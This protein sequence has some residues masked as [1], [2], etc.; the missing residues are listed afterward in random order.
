MA[1]EDESSRRREY[2][3]DSILATSDSVY[4]VEPGMGIKLKPTV[5]LPVHKKSRKLPFFKGQNLAL[6]P[7]GYP[8]K[9]YLQQKRPVFCILSFL[10]AISGKRP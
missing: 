8:H 1:E 5:D 7:K 4:A 9:T 6:K 2:K 10:L 3:I